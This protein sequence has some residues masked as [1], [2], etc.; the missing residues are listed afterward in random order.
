MVKQL[1]YALIYGAGVGFLA[2]KLHISME[3]AKFL[4]QDFLSNHPGIPIFIKNSIKFVHSNGYVES[5]M[6]R[7]R[8]F[9]K[10]TTIT[11]NNSKD[12]GKI[13]RQA[14][15]SICQG[16]AADV[17]K[18]AMVHIHIKIKEF[19]QSEHQLSNNNQDNL[20][21]PSNSREN[22]KLSDIRLILQIHDELLF[23]IRDDY[24]DS[25]TRIIR[26]CMENCVKL[27]IPL[28][29]KMKIG[30]DWGN[31]DDYSCNNNNN[32]INNNNNN[33][34]NNNNNNNIN[35]SEINDLNFS[36]SNNE[37]INIRK[38]M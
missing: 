20:I 9:T 7:K 2:E 30:K 6:G 3:E 4:N 11:T 35:Q 5:M 24:I 27:K 19:L 22:T 10:N 16:S 28:Q 15:N 36:L 34:I 31:M 29:V 13:D 26:D 23:E 12:K 17:I 18:L 25:T 32:N 33:N 38:W 1:C 21:S 14:V 37:D 8:Y